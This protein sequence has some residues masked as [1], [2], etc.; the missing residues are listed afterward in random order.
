[1]KAVI[2]AGG[3]G[4][5]LWPM[6]NNR[7]PKQFQAFV[8]HE[9]MLQQTYARLSFLRPENIYVSTIAEYLP[10]VRKQL[11]KL[12]QKN[13]IIESAMRDTGPSICNAAHYLDKNGNGK[14]VMTIIYADHLIK[15]ETTFR[16]SL[17]TA[18]DFA[19]TTNKF[20]VIGVKA[21]YPNVTLGYIRIGKL[22]EK[23]YL[24][25]EEFDIYELDR[26]VEKPTLEKAQQF[27]NSYKYFWNTGLYVGSVQM[28]LNEFKKHSPEIYRAIVMKENYAAAPKI[29]IDYALIEKLTSNA[30]FVIPVDLGW[31][32]IGNW[33]SL[34]DELTLKKGANVIAANHIG[35]DT[36]G[37]LIIGSRKKKIATIGLQDMIIIDT[38][39]ALLIV[40]KTRAPDVKNIVNKLKE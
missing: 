25:K 1:M 16:Y 37:S 17:Q 24:K 15:K 14:D 33:Q 20:G 31:N 35:I 11:K 22:L 27:L 19:H 21:L 23:R 3:T 5:R 40:P 30:M 12:S 34:Y 28:F 7:Q 4:T 13:I 18:V 29:S 2:M 9:T 32:D 39:D 38:P 36:T 10:L 6:S 26:F 8:G